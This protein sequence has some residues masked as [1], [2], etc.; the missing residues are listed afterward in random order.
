[1]NMSIPFVNRNPKTSKRRCIYV[2]TVC[3]LAITFTMLVH[4]RAHISHHF[5]GPLC[6]TLQYYFSDVITARTMAINVLGQRDIHIQCVGVYSTLQ[7]S[8]RP[9]L[10]YN[11]RPV[12]VPGHVKNIK[13]VSSRKG[14]LYGRVV[15]S[16]VSRGMTEARRE[17]MRQVEVEDYDVV[18]SAPSMLYRTYLQRN[19]RLCYERN[20]TNQPRRL[21]WSF[22]KNNL[23][24]I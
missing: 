12:D 8:W 4:Y 1:M 16:W 11:C 7:S 22:M 10:L 20:A 6:C 2:Y 15:T 17:K 3:T 21:W 18:Y 9:H 5:P 24:S 14:G 19:Y 13:I 23:R